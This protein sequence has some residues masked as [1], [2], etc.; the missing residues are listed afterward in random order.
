MENSPSY[1]EIMQ[2]RVDEIRA[3]V[4]DEI[5]ARKEKVKLLLIQRNKEKQLERK[6]AEENLRASLAD[7]V[8]KKKLKIDNIE[9]SNN[10][11]APTKKPIFVQ[12]RLNF[13]KAGTSRDLLNEQAGTSKALLPEKIETKASNLKEKEKLLVVEENKETKT[14]PTSQRKLSASKS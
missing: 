12:T 9:L 14:K 11:K 6:Q 7:I 3:K 10:D 5:I 13:Q 4:E 1:E 2:G 8:P